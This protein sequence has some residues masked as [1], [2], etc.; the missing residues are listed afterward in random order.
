MNIT[1]ENIDALN[2]VVTVAIEKK[3]YNKKVEKILLDYRK[4][5]NIPGF[6]KGQ[7]PMGMVKKQYGKAVL[8]DEVNKILQ[9]NLNKY[10][11]AEKL[12]LL[13]N[14][15]PRKQDDLNWDGED[16]SFQ[17]ELGLAPSFDVNLK[18]KEAITQYNI[19]ADEKTINDQIENIRKQYG[20]I[21]ATTEITEETEITGV[22]KN[23]EKAIES[24]TTFS[25]DKIKGKTNTG[26]FLKAKIGDILILKTENLFNQEHDLI[27]ALK[28]SNEDVQGSDIEVTFEITETNNRALAEMDQEFFDKLFGKDIVKSESELK[29]R[30]KEDAGKQFAQQADQRLLNDV[31]EHLVENTKFDLPQTFL[32]K[33]MQNSGENP[34]TEEQA[35]EEYAKSEKA[36]RYQLIEGKL[37]KENDI[38]V[39]FEDLKA[40][41]TETVRAQMAQFG[42]TNPSDEELEGIVARVLSNQ[43][44]ARK[45]GEQLVSKKLLTFYKDNINLKVK[46]LNYEEFIKEVYN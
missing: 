5:A 28:V 44:E 11:A 13:G 4:K 29:A 31:T 24:T 39:Q 35:K 2:A 26:K 45:L 9:E 18:N 17:F 14:P 19:V 34:L 10:L 46:E 38:Q 32:E 21:S 27:S 41:T 16:F 36:L 15:L 40:H 1:R 6:R 43:D 30:L 37:L 3:D 7:V 42:Q 25:L 33:W 12:D 20:K 8:V 23:E 22:F